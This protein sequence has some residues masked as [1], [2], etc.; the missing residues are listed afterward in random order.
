MFIKY[1]VRIKFL[2]KNVTISFIYI[3]YGQN[4]TVLPK[5]EVSMHFKVTSILYITGHST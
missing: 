1:F 4:H 2:K 3:S 5:N